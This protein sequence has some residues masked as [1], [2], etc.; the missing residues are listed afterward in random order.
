MFALFLKKN[1][2]LYYIEF[3]IAFALKRCNFVHMT[4]KCR[5]VLFVTMAKLV[6][7]DEVLTEPLYVSAYSLAKQLKAT[8]V[9]KAVTTSEHHLVV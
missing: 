3:N 4:C 2:F 8:R 9:S 1:A 6:L 5:Q 7:H